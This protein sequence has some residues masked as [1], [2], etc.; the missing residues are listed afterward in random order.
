MARITVPAI[1]KQLRKE[2]GEAAEMIANRIEYAV[3]DWPTAR[4]TLWEPSWSDV[5]DL[6]KPMAQIALYHE[7]SRK[8]LDFGYK[9]I[10]L[11]NDTLWDRHRAAEVET[12]YLFDAAGQLMFAVSGEEGRVGFSV[13]GR[14]WDGRKYNGESWHNHPANGHRAWGF[15][16]SPTDVMSHMTHGHRASWVYAKEGL[17]LMRN[18]VLSHLG[19]SNKEVDKMAAKARD[20]CDRVWDEVQA[21]LGGSAFFSRRL[22]CEMIERMNAEFSGIAQ[23]NGFEYLFRPSRDFLQAKGIVPR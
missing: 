20:D 16:P 15:P 8:G 23:R 12:L 19:L 13:D 3:E 1:A 18:C 22:G 21:D 7:A 11:N 17:Y 2:G 5:N 4:R 9:R 14:I 10:D 6:G